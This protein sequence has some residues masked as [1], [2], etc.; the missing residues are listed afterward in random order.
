MKELSNRIN[1]LGVVAG[2]VFIITGILSFFLPLDAP[3][4]TQEDTALWH[5]NTAGPYLFGWLNQIIAMLA[6]SVVLAVAAWQIFPAA[7]LR[8]GTVWVLTVSSTVVFL[9][10]KFLS[11][12]AV[13]L[14][15]KAIAAGSN[16]SEAAATL[17]SALGPSTAFGLIPSMDYLGF[18]LYA[19]IGFFAFRPLFRLSWS[20]KI[21]A[22]VLLIY[23]IAF[24]LVG[25]AVLI[26]ILSQS[27]VGDSVMSIAY[28]VAI[29]AI[30]SLFHFRAPVLSNPKR[31]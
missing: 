8:A 14:L 1:T 16:E 28:L 3:A 29:A 20:A 18:W 6:L 10:S 15:A 11:I 31:A 13:P 7:P 27:Q 22:V 17:L 5:M 26:D 30:A 19:L 4:P 9:I 23:G 25:I 21:A 24:H 12:W 2:A